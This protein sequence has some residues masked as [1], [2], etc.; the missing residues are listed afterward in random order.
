MTH[1]DLI[2]ELSQRLDWTQAKTSGTLDAAVEI[3]NEKLAENVSVS[4]Q[5]FGIFE[6]KK[7]SERVSVNPLTQERFLVPPKITVGF[8]PASGIKDKL[9][10]NNNEEQ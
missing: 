5:N 9:R 4:I 2:A 1:K 3:L 6:T 7:K 10:G 8:K